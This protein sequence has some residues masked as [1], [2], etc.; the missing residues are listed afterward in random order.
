MISWIDSKADIVTYGLPGNGEVPSQ[1]RDESKA[2]GP[3]VDEDAPEVI[4]ESSW[5]LKPKYVGIPSKL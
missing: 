5:I 3:D 4:M 1:L 2:I